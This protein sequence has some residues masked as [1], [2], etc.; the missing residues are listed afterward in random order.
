MKSLV[1]RHFTAALLFCFVNTVLAQSSGQIRLSEAQLAKSGISFTEIKAVSTA[2]EGLRLAGS[3]VYPPNR[4][5]IIST[6]AAGVVQAVLVNSMDRVKIGQVLARLHSPELLQWQRDYVQQTTQLEL[7]TKKAERDESLF[8]EGIIA[9]SRLQETR[10]QLQ[11][12]RVAVQ[13]RA[14][15]LKLSGMSASAVARLN[16]QSGLNPLIEIHS[17]SGGSVL[18]LMLQPGQRVEAGAALAKVARGGELWLELQAS[19]AQGDQIAMGDTVNVGACKQSGKVTAIAPQMFEQSQLVIVRASLPGAEQCLR[20]GQYLEAAISSKQLPSSG[21]VI[22][23]AAL[24]RNGG[25]EFIFVRNAAGVK[26]VVVTVL[27]RAV[28]HLIVQGPLTAGLQVAVQGTA[29]LK[30]IWLG[31]GVSGSE[32][33]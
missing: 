7:A 29:S 33:K 10:N 12:S 4:I 32:A 26:P 6:P 20:P 13:E 11:Q 28:D 21:W 5:E 27:T 1:I 8:N 25:S 24:V 18:E 23:S 30:G 17:Q 22:P 9:A 31:L 14:Q 15:M 3:V 2:T 19:R 16:S